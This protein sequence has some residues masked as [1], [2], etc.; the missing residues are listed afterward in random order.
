MLP[1]DAQQSH[2]PFTLTALCSLLHGHQYCPIYMTSHMVPFT[3][4]A[5]CSLLHVQPYVPFYM[6]IHMVPFT[7]TTIFH[8][9][10]DSSFYSDN[11]TVPSAQIAI[12]F[13]LLREPLGPFYSDSHTILFIWTVMWYILCKQ[14]KWPPLLR[15]TNALFYLVNHTVPFTQT[16]KIFFNIFIYDHGHIYSFLKSQLFNQY[17]CCYYGPFLWSPQVI[18]LIEKNHRGQS[19]NPSWVEMVY[20]NCVH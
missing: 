15:R 7:W 20:W 11:I 19:R 2:C 12:W 4:P 1:I 5:I 18:L 17:C 3:W 8:M 6:D 13:L 16:T 14:P 9:Y 10:N